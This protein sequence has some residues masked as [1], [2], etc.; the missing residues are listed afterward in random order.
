MQSDVP[1]WFGKLSMLGDFASRRLSSDWIRPCDEWLSASMEASRARLGERWLPAYLAAPVWRFAW[2]PGIVDEQWWFGVLMP[3]CDNVGRYFPLVVTQARPQPPSDRFALDHLEW[4][5][6][7]L[8]RA[9]LETLG[10]GAGLD[11]FEQALSDAPPWPTGTRPG[12]SR[13]LT[14]SGRERYALVDG[15]ALIDLAQDLAAEGLRRRLVG[16]SFWWPL[17]TER[18]GGSCTLATGLPT[19]AAFAELL[20]GDW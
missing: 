12:W 9:S 3:S 5:W 8:A 13:P 15:A 20:A 6:S 7:H 11:A 17:H 18:G 19:A 10:N 4:W 1:G 14:A 2:A 16:M